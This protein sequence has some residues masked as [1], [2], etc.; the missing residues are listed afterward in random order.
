MAMIDM[1]KLTDDEKRVY[2][3]HQQTL[4]RF[5]RMFPEP[6]KMVKVQVATAGGNVLDWLVGTADKVVMERSNGGFIVFDTHQDGA[7]DGINEY[8]D[9]RWHP[10]SPSFDWALGG[11]ILER[12]HLQP[13]FQ[14]HGKY[15]GLWAC[16]KWV[17]DRSGATVA[18]RQYGPTTLIAAMRCHVA[19]KLGDEAEVPEELK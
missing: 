8:N 4:D 7:P 12:E 15:K 18:I 16:N 13:S 14:E 6:K 5:N 19:S 10:Y 3:M 1:D 2:M 9:A 17:E 11:P